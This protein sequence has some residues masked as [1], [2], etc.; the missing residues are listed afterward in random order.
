M[1]GDSGV[2]LGH[3]PDFAQLALRLFGIR[4]CN[5]LDFLHEGQIVH[6]DAVLGVHVV[7]A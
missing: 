1:T 3:G 2:N 5:K 4:G 7:R 6:V